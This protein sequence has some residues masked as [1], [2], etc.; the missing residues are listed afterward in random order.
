MYDQQ[1][2]INNCGSI[3]MLAKLMDGVASEYRELV[4][5]TKAQSA[6]LN[7]V[8]ANQ[9]REFQ[10]QQ[11]LIVQKSDHGAVMASL[12]HLRD[13]IKTLDGRI[14][15]LYNTKADKDDII[16]KENLLTKADMVKLATILGVLFTGVTFAI[17]IISPMIRAMFKV[18]WYNIFGNG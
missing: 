5:V 8:I 18:T 2:P 10:L 4:E 17:Q 7:S 9:D 11:E 6:K 3:E 1:C 12:T 15:T 14:V 16:S 13:D